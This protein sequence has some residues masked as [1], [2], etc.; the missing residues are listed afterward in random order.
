MTKTIFQLE[1]GDHILSPYFHGEMKGC[2]VYE[3]IRPSRKVVNINGK[4]Q[5]HES[6]GFIKASID[7]LE[8]KMIYTEYGLDSERKFEL[9]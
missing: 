7:D 5:L 1:V 6:I 4:D 8:G 9:I 3:Q 2:K